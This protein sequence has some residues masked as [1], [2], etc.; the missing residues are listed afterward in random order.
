[1]FRRLYWVTEEIAEDGASRVTGV[2]TS[3]PDLIRHG[4][5]WTGSPKKTFRLSLVK[6]DC[7]NDPLGCFE[8]PRYEGLE[9]RLQDFVKTNEFSVEECQSL[10][11]ALREFS[12]V[13]R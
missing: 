1:M 4:L 5:R 9:E 2:Y 12:S 6:L 3:V 10:A 8:S 11:D 13:A 7:N